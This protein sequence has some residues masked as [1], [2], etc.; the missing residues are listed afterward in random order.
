MID[1]TDVAWRTS[2]RTSNGSGNCVEV[3]VVSA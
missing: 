1:L 2:T 3:G